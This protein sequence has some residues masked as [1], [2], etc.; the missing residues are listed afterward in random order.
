MIWE[1]HITLFEARTLTEEAALKDSSFDRSFTNASPPAINARMLSAKLRAMMSMTSLMRKDVK[2]LLLP[3]TY[4]L[5]RWATHNPRILEW[6]KVWYTHFLQWSQ[7]QVSWWTLWSHFPQNLYFYEA[8]DSLLSLLMI[9]YCR[10]VSLLIAL[11]IVVCST[12]S[13]C[14]LVRW[15]HYWE[16]D[17]Y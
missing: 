5:L 11:I 13:S 8:T 14:C 7:W 2:R 3:F 12:A 10:T 6:K 15:W 9:Q 16:I 4:V 1:I 17:G